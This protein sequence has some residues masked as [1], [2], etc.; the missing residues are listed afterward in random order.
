M[1]PITACVISFNEERKI[2]QCLASL[3]GVVDEIVLVDSHSTDRTLE[4]AAPY[5]DKI[6][7]QEFL[8]HIEQKN[9]AVAQA[10][11]D[12]ILSLDCDECLTPEL[13]DSITKRKPA[14]DEHPAYEFTRKTFY[15]YRWLEHT[16]YPEYRTR[17]FDRRRAR[18]AGTN[19]HDKVE[20]DEGRP[21]RLT[22]DLE[23]Y[24]F[25]SISDHIKTLDHFT[26]IAARELI[27][28][29]KPVTIL[30][31]FTHACWVFF[32]LYILRRGFLDGLAGISASV[33]SFMHVFAKYTKVLT[34]RRRARL[35]L[36]SEVLG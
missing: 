1:Q 18:W 32:K 26:E 14:L 21:Q 35:G 2:V 16:W 4:L 8:G 9:F 31:P 28:R 30:T 6:I 25:D 10:S 19:P 22:G 13:A 24:S 3:R 23:H 11:H 5:A 15:V 34:Y 7:S 36:D 33:L 27:K 20:L 17:L 29:N 12:W